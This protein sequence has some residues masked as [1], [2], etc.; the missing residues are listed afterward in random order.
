MLK[1]TVTA[2]SPFTRLLCD[3]NISALLKNTK[4]WTVLKI[5]VRNTATQR[6]Q[7]H[8]DVPSSPS[9]FNKT[10]TPSVKQSELRAVKKT[11]ATAL[12]RKG[13]EFVLACLLSKLWVN[14]VQMP[15]HCWESVLSLF[16][17]VYWANCGLIWCRCHS[18][19]EKGFWVCSRLFTEQTVG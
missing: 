7:K 1:G 12:L 10:N 3:M 17:P 16:S 11:L 2:A 6:P 13:F 9:C 15:Q 5:I 8:T 18:I 14:L 4:W 19:V